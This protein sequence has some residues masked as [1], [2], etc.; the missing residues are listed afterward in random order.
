MKLF[1]TASIASM[2]TGAVTALWL[3]GL[4]GGKS[5]AAFA[6]INVDGWRSDWSIGSASANPSTRTRVARHG[7]LALTKGEAVY[8]TTDQDNEGKTLR[9]ECDY[10]ISGGDQDAFWWS[11]TLYDHHSRLPMNNDSALSIDATSLESREIWT[12]RISPERPKQNAAWISSRATQTFDL[13]LRI[14]RPSFAIIENPVA[15]I[16]APSIKRISC[17]GG[18]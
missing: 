10:E 6:D 12:A 17:T 16:N 9:E 5:P 14:Y 11:I 8:F 18:A 1:M 3:A 13:T 4:I 15:T 2:I 7:L